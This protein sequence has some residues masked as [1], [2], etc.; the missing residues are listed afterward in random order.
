LLGEIKE[1][2][3]Q[4]GEFREPANRMILEEFQKY[5]SQASVEPYAIKR[6]QLFLENAFEYYLGSRTKGKII[7]NK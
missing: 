6:R 4:L 7:G 2:L 5:I 1:N 3:K